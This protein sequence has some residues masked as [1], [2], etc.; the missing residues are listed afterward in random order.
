MKYAATGVLLSSLLILSGGRGVG[1]P[2]LCQYGLEGVEPPK[3][4]EIKEITDYHKWTLINPKPYYV[5]ATKAVNCAAIHSGSPHE[6]KFIKVYVNAIGQKALLTQKTPQF[7]PGSVIVKEKSPKQDSAIPELLTVMIKRAPGYDSKKGD[8]EY[9]LVD[10][11]PEN[12]GNRGK[13]SY[14]QSCHVPQQ[15]R[16]YIFRTYLPDAVRQKLH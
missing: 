13:L 6:G 15:A 3:P 1:R 8:W 14:C 5:P 11:Q 2:K 9:L 4:R 10:K 16:G 7:A 12:E